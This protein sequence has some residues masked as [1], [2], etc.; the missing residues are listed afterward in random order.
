M[1]SLMSVYLIF[2]CSN[3]TRLFSPASKDEMGTCFVFEKG[4]QRIK[5]Y[6]VQ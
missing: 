5:T 6:R 1:Y 4:L 3:S 2:E